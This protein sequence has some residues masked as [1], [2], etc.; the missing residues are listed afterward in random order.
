MLNPPL[1]SQ[2]Q[3]IN[4]HPLSAKGRFNRLSYLGWYGLLS[5]TCMA[6]LIFLMLMLFTGIVSIH[7]VNLDTP[8]LSAFPDLMIFAMIALWC[9]MAEPAAAR[10]PY[11]VAVYIL[12]VTCPRYALSQ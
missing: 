12:C 9:A 4:D 3:P 7:N 5:L 2:T 1:S 11:P 10:P 8:M 6:V